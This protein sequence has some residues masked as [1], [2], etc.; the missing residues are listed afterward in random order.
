MTISWSQLVNEA[1][2][3]DQFEA[4][5][6]GPYLLKVESATAKTA[7][8]GKKMFAIKYRIQGGPHN[9]RVIFNNIVL[10][11]DNANALGYFFR[12]MAAHGL[13]RSYFASD[14]SD[15]QIVNALRDRE[16]RADLGIRQYNGENQNEIKNYYAAASQGGAPQPGAAAQPPA[17]APQPPAPAP[18]PPVQAP[19]PQPQ[20]AA[21]APAPAPAPQPMAAPQ[22]QEQPQYAPQPQE[23]QQAQ[24]IPQPPPP[25]F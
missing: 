19:A 25:P 21:P 9:N 24:S 16:V 13:D 18:Q 1:G 3:A 12:N 22:P 10:T 2:T 7:S 14:P 23:P 15:D 17:P 6:A 20:Y 11:T 8:T 4:V 5:P